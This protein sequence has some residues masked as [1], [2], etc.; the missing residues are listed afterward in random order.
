MSPL[1]LVSCYLL[2]AE[3]DCPLQSTVM[4]ITPPLRL[5]HAHAF[6]CEQHDS[7]HAHLNMAAQRHKWSQTPQGVFNHKQTLSDL[8]IFI[9]NMLYVI[10]S[11]S[12]FPYR[13]FH[14]Q[15]QS[16][17]SIWHPGPFFAFQYLS[18]DETG[19]GGAAIRPL[20][21]APPGISPSIHLCGK[22]K[23]STSRNTMSLRCSFMSISMFAVK[24][25][26]S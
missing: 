13:T 6:S 8:V 5:C 22:D 15:W 26:L 25:T 20:Q 12:V 16:P 9:C 19:G 11:F 3:N 24:A 21:S 10:I 7:K 1:L 17:C 2:L 18:E 23:M 14:S 4:C